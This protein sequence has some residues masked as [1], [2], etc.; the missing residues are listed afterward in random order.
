VGYGTIGPEEQ[1][2]LKTKRAALSDHAVRSAVAGANRTSKQWLVR[3]LQGSGRVQLPHRERDD[4]R[5]GRDFWRQWDPRRY[6]A[7]ELERHLFMGVVDGLVACV[8]ALTL[9]AHGFTMKPI[10]PEHLRVLLVEPK[11]G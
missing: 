11:R 5:P 1:S 2:L 8:I 6:K 4:G 7:L 10:G 3:R 9:D